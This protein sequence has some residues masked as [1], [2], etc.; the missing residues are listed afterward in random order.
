[1]DQKDKALF[2]S[3]R[4]LLVRLFAVPLLDDTSESRASLLAPH[5]AFHSLAHASSQAITLAPKSKEAI[6]ARIVM[7]G[8]GISDV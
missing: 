2:P 3:T 8:G 6:P 1:M 5:Q 7:L 4:L